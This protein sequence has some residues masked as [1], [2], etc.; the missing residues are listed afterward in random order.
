MLSWITPGSCPVPQELC[1]AES[2]SRR[3]TRIDRY[4]SRTEVTNDHITSA[5]TWLRLPVLKDGAI[6]IAKPTD[7]NMLYRTIP[8]TRG[9]P[10]DEALNHILQVLASIQAND[11]I[12]Y[13]IL[14][15]NTSTAAAATERTKQW[16][17]AQETWHKLENINTMIISTANHKVD[18]YKW[19][20]EDRVTYV[21]FNNHDTPS[22]VFKI[23]SALMFESN[24]FEEN[25]N[26]F[27][28]AWLTGSEE[29]ICAV[30]KEYFEDYRNAL[31]DRNRNEA[32]EALSKAIVV[33][34]SSEFQQRIT[35]IEN[36]I[37]EYFN[38]ISRLTENLNKVKAE[39]LLYALEDEEDKGEILKN[40]FISCKNN[41]THLKFK[42]DKLQIVYITNL[43]YFES[44]MLRTYLRTTRDNCVNK[45]PAYIQQLLKDIF[46]N[47][48]YKLCIE[49]GVILDTQHNNIQYT[50]PYTI[51]GV[52]KEN[53]KGIPNP[54]HRYYNCWGDNKPNI[55][56]A[57][58]NKDYITAI[59]TCF[60]A[61]AGLNIAD[62][63]V[64]EK[65]IQDELITYDN[66]PCLKNVKTGEIITITQY[67][68]R[69]EERETNEA[70]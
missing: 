28:E 8:V 32:I 39:Y 22:V 1:T 4:R 63:A 15:L 26:K 40:F 10:E 68:R 58:M 41:I 46:L 21:I 53:L 5:Y 62:V 2:I 20:L 17:D 23:A 19:Q 55:V 49:S 70:N 42:D 48:I 13:N 31:E 33:D 34:K 59:L 11:Y 14:M 69:Y 60:A 30:V 47:N 29:K 3:R 12:K 67:K 24:R 18:I 35:Y 65:F 56:N 54:H 38:E 7:F 57:M 45:A 9:I 36:D 51:R 50:E 43:M 44:D 6:N 61:I 25:T 64:M 27:V 52:S 37:N 16:F 66:V